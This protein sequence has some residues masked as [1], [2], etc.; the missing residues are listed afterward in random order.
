[1]LTFTAVNE[2]NHVQLDSIK[3]INR[4]QNCDT[5]LHWP[6]TVISVYYT[7][8]AE[9]NMSA[10]D[11]QL[12][13]N[14]PNPVTANTTVS[15]VVPER[16]KVSIIVSDMLG[17]VILRNEK[18]LNQGLNSFRFIPGQGSLFFFTV[19]WRGMSKSIKIIQAA[20]SSDQRCSLEFIGHTPSSLP[21]KTIENIQGFDFNI[22]DELLYIGYS[23]N[24]QSALLSALK[25]NSTVTFQFATNIPCPGTPAVE[26]E[27]QVY[28][29][30]QIFNQC[31]MKENINA[32]TMIP[33][34]NS[35]SDNGIL[36]KYCYNNEPDS[37]T[38]YGGLYQFREMMQY[39]ALQSAKGICPEGWHIPSDE[40]WKILEG[41]V[42][43]QYGIGDPEWDLFWTDRGFDAGTN[44][45]SASG[46]NGGGNG[47]DLFGF[48]FLPGGESPSV[49]Y[50]NGTVTDG[51]LWSSTDYHY[52]SAWCRYISYQSAEVYRGFNDKTA[53]LSVRCVKDIENE[54]PAFEL[55]FTG[56]NNAV[57]IKLD[58]VRIINRTQ[59]IET[60]LYWPDTIIVLPLELNIQ[61]GDE[62]LCIGHSND[63]ESGILRSPES[64]AAY[65]F[66][67]ATNIPCP[68]TPT[69]E[70]KGHV[71]NTIQILSQCWLKENLNVG[72]MIDSLEYM[73]DNDVIEK[74]CY[75]NSPDSCEKYGA[76]YQ[77][78][79]MMQYT[80][81]QG[82]QGICPPGWHIPTDEEWKILEGALDSRF[83]IGSNAW[84]IDEDMRGFDAGR[85]LKASTGWIPSGNN[86]TDML[87][88]SG[89]PGGAHDLWNH[90]LNVGHYGYW[91]TSTEKGYLS[92]YYRYPYISMIARGGNY[93]AFG[94]SVRCIRNN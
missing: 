26:Y 6:D 86:G 42:D 72:A 1:M 17:R 44:L 9:T 21:L 54:L 67:F 40:E 12:F 73:S 5:V 94:F 4:T 79:E 45:K 23:N 14:Y 93:A 65:T 19:K 18:F 89:L 58:S 55:T 57:N 77:F 91:W 41:A 50:F 15:M 20:P 11:F 66:E 56:V 53:S 47:A 62:L 48:S 24:A 90:F 13:Q 28:N 60:M 88:F 30:I 27:G 71:Y 3:I 29:T 49:G 81:Q 2:E 83:E 43:G 84:D 75:R 85:N 87:G 64:N 22:G 68:G 35:M 38:K 36:E 59:N 32:G 69:V 34:D 92:A 25:S 46:W 76:L 78:W 52:F 7:G 37:C 39:S 31:W 51:S 70:F 82:V 8:I 33:A 61:P 10:G 74:Y 63:L 80:T 16:S